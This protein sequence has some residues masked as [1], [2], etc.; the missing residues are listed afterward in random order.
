MKEKPD[1]VLV[2]G[3][4]NTTLAGGLAACKLQIKAGHIETDLKPEEG[5]S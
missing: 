5:I 3:Y 2:F 1:L 4:T